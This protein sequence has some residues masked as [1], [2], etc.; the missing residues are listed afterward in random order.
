M[1]NAHWLSPAEVASRFVRFSA[2]VDMTAEIAARC[3]NCL[4]DGRA[5]W[6]A[7]KLPATQT[8]DEALTALATEGLQRRYTPLCGILRG[9]RAIVNRRSSFVLHP[10]C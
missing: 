4:P 10:S 9:P 8:P 3:G 6:P 2:A 5:I 1:K 7:L